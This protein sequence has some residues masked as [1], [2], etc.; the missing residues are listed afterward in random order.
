MFPS[1]CLSFLFF[2]PALKTTESSAKRDM[3]SARQHATRRSAH[4]SNR[5][6]KDFDADA[7]AAR[8]SLE[9]KE[10]KYLFVNGESVAHN[11]RINSKTF[12]T[13][14][15]LSG[16]VA[17][18]VAATDIIGLVFYSATMLVVGTATLVFR[19]EN[20]PKRFVPESIGSAIFAQGF[21][22]GFASIIL[23]WT[24]FYN[25]CHLF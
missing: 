24:L 20:E 2:L 18:I 6:L 4:H 23:F 10:E 1:L 21:S 16:S 13:L 17:G 8:K 9:E 25:V 11:A 19:C 7:S 15:I 5:N 14:S 3:S 22:G 12:T